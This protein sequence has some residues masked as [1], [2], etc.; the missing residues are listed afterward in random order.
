MEDDF[1]D[2]GVGKVFEWGLMIF[3]ILAIFIF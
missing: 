3:I 1:W 2:S